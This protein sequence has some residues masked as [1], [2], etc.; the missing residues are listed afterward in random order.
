M[1]RSGI[2]AT[3]NLGAQE[4]RIEWTPPGSPHPDQEAVLDFA[5]AA[6]FTLQE[7]QSRV[8]GDSLLEKRRGKWASFENALVVPRQ[9]GKTE[10]AIVRTLAGALVLEEKLIIYTAHLGRTS[11]EVFRR[12]CDKIAEVDWIDREV[13]HVW[14]ST[15]RESIEFKN[16]ARIL[17]QT[18]TPSS[19]RG[20]AKAHCVIMDEAMYLPTAAIASIL[21][22]LGRAQNPQ[23][24]YL[25]SS[26]DQVTQ[27][28]SVAL[29]AV[30]ERALSQQDESLYYAEWSMPYDH[31]S[32]VPNAVLAD[33][34]AWAASNPALGYGLPEEHVA[35]EFRG[36]PDKRVFAIER[37]GVGD[38]PSLLETDGIIDPEAWAQLADPGGVITGK[39][40]FALDVSPD[41]AWA[42]IAVAGK[43]GDDLLQVEIVEHRRGTGW[44]VPWLAERKSK[45]ILDARSPAGSLIPALEQARIEVEPVTTGEHCRA[46]GLFYDAVAEGTLRHLD[47]TLLSIALA[48]ARSRQVGDSWLWSRDPTGPDISPLV[49]ATLALWGAGSAQPNNFT[50]V[51]FA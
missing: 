20:F 39:G 37:G 35:N 22:I 24:W 34:V 12:T 19:G 51:A 43:R 9:N 13:R 48:A 36:A 21:F 1:T 49:A 40:V 2:A 45:V 18:R 30:R 31:P 50:A 8:L 46:C 29:A 7:W 47:D 3:R 41:R 27:P 44:V 28:D 38:W 23:L 10:L 42:S 15:G 14:R 33:P 16:G 25:G 4:P 26:P 6:G 17:F 11:Q 32:D 5:E